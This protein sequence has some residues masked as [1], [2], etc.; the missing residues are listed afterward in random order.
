MQVYWIYRISLYKKLLQAFLI[1][2]PLEVII[3][4]GK[5][6]WHFTKSPG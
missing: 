4:P 1:L 2:Q 5:T 3:Y 6:A